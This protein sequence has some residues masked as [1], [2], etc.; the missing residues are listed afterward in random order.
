MKNQ[1]A[2]FGKKLNKKELKSI[3]GGMYDC[4]VPEP[5]EPYPGTCESHAD[6]NGCTMIHP[7]CGQ[8]ICR[9]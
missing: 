2:Q 6:A 7:K 5:C 8:A 3:T 1:F 4:M 9:P